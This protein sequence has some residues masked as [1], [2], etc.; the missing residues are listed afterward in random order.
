MGAIVSILYTVVVSPVVI[1]V[2]AML[3]KMPVLQK[4]KWIY[5]LVI[6]AIIWLIALSQAG[7]STG[8]GERKLSKYSMVISFITSLIV[9]ASTT[10]LILFKK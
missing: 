10:F 3:R 4:I 5:V 1:G 2:C 8:P 9:V 6:S 7:F